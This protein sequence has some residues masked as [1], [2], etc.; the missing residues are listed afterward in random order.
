MDSDI[1][2]A[3]STVD[4]LNRFDMRIELFGPHGN[5]TGTRRSAIQHVSDAI[6]VVPN[7][8]L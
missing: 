3:R 5:V 7:Q 6:E 4:H 8:A 2:L 1:D